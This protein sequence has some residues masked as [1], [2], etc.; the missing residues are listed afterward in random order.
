MRI[1][2]AN[3]MRPAGLVLAT[4]NYINDRGQILASAQLPDGSTP[5]FILTPAERH[6]RTSG[7]I[8]VG[9]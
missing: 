3:G 9:K 2:T 8:G 4:A 1:A 7:Q 6:L 5:T